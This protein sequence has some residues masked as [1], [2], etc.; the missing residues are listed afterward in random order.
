MNMVFA[1]KS[2]PIP[3]PRCMVLCSNV[4]CHFCRYADSTLQAATGRLLTVE[5]VV[6]QIQ[7]TYRHFSL[8]S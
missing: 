8:V 6:F 5:K 3:N 2:L 4:P 7:F 1:L